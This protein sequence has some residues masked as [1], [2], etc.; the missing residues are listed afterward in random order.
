MPIIAAGLLLAVILLGL[1]VGAGWTDSADWR[2]AHAL[3]FRAGESSATVIS[4]MQG[5]SWIGGGTPRWIIVILL[6]ALVWHWC[7]PRCAAALGC[8]SLLSNLASSLLKLG[9]GRARPDL[10]DH[11]DHQT[12][13]SYPSGHATSAA[14]VY[15]L[16]ASLA[17]PRWRPLAWTLAFAMIIL[18]GFSRIMLGVHWASDIVGGTML[19]AAFA[20]FGTW[21]VARRGLRQS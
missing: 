15:L 10:I 14:A 16:L 18:N 21:A 3:S 12:S 9:F 19:G 7:G 11:L 5:V 17:P 1:A 4:F 8:V 13:F 6:C 20:L 2:I